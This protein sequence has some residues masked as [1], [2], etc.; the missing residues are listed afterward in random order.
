LT[1]HRSAYLN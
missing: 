1:P